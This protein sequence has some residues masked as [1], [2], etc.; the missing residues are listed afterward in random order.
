M[1]SIIINGNFPNGLDLNDPLTNPVTLT[2]TIDLG[3]SGQFGALQ[4]ETVAAWDVTNQGTIQ[5]GTEADG[6]DLLLG[7]TVTN[8]VSAL[9]SGLFAVEIQGIAGTV[10]NAGTLDGGANSLDATGVDL[11]AG[12]TVTNQTG[13]LIQSADDGVTAQGSAGV[14]TNA[15]IIN[16][17]TGGA[18][19]D[20]LAG[21]SVSNQAGGTLTGNW[22]ISIQGAATGSVVNDGIVTGGTQAGVFISGGSVT[23]QPRARSAAPGAFPSRARPARF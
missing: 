13:G 8:D 4:G 14:V 15:G 18:A 17:G 6:I 5:G 12:G 19:V 9:V 2:G 23:N 11:T 3:T 7:G 1:T 22:G 16:A 10:V 21:G 20:L